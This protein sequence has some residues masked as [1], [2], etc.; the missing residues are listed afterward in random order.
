MQCYLKKKFLEHL[1]VLSN[2]TNLVKKQCRNPC[3]RS[4]FSTYEKKKR[5]GC[6]RIS[7]YVKMVYL[8]LFN[9]WL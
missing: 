9:N 5:F 7:S 2:H 4:E 6:K 3:Q 8:L 1:R